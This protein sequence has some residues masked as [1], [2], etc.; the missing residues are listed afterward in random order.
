[1]IKCIAPTLDGSAKTTAVPPGKAL[2]AVAAPGCHATC[3]THRQ[4][5]KIRGCRP[6][7]KPISTRRKGLAPLAAGRHIQSSQAHMMVPRINHSGAAQNVTS[8]NCDHSGSGDAPSIAFA[9]SDDAGVNP[10][11][12][13]TT[14]NPEMDPRRSM[15]SLIRL[16]SAL[17][18][19]P[20]RCSHGNGRALRGG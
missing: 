11:S 19:Q 9:F 7:S 17:L 8:S 2:A 13:A 20:A 15:L 18:Q 10:A 5:T 6:A 16:T 14:A 3:A 12:A 1:M 4:T